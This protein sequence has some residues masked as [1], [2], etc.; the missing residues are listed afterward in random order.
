MGLTLAG[1]ALK[2]GKGFN[3]AFGK[4]PQKYVI[5]VTCIIA[6]AIIGL[7]M[8]LTLCCCYNQKKNISSVK[9]SEPSTQTEP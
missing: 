1:V 4:Y 7:L 2:A 9:P 8:F 5:L 6:V 3:N